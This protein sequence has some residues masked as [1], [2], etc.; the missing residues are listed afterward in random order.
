MPRAAEGPGQDPLGKYL[1]APVTASVV[2]AFHVG[3]LFLLSLYGLHRYWILFLFWRHYKSRPPL[4]TPPPPSSWPRV[5]V[6]LPLFNEWYVV[7]RLLDAVCALDYPRNRLQIQLLDDS[8]DES[9]ALACRLAQVRRDEGFDVSH[10]HRADRRGFKAGALANGLSSATGEFV[11][12]F[13]AD[14]LPPRDFL[15]RTLPHFRD[16]GLGMVQARWGHINTGYS[17]L[18][19]LQALFLDGHFLLEHTARNRSGAF[20]NFNGTAGLWRRRAI[21]E[22]GG[23]SDDTLTEDLDISYRAQMKGWRFLFL[24]DLVCPAELPVDMG[25]F[26]NQQ[27]RWTKGALQVAKKILPDLWR[28]STSLFVKLESTIHLTSNLGYLLLL[29]FSLLL[30]PSLAARRA[31]GWPVWVNFLEAGAFALTALSIVVFYSVAQREAFGGP[32]RL[33]GGDLPALMVFGVGMCLNNGRAVLEALF[34]IPT[35]FLRTAKFNI[36][37][38]GEGWRDKRY[39]TSRRPVG[40]LEL[41]AGA[42]LAAALGWSVNA[43]YFWSL[44]FI[45]V[46]LAGYVYV[47]YLSL[48]HALQRA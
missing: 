38:K 47:G 28:G 45:G 22:A 1:T 41:A 5:T 48:R 9:R 12:I 4:T 29:V 32:L 36:R 24:P 39:R 2:L 40:G 18:T 21:D 42:Y 8:T 46:F 30:F 10:I 43:G 25:A 35:E 26:R 19:R 3:I 20:F 37:A 17:L 31:L 27:H 23:W 33:R 14:F 15:K 16:A 11:A 7:E 44:P 6:Q 34:N 13:D